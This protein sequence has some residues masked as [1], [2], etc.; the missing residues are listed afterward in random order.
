MPR[1]TKAASASL[2]SWPRSWRLESSPSSTAVQ[3]FRPRSMRLLMPCAGQNESWKKSTGAAVAIEFQ[4]N[5]RRRGLVFGGRS[6]RLLLHTF[7]AQGQFGGASGTPGWPFQQDTVGIIPTPLALKSG[8]F[9]NSKYKKAA[10]QLPLSGL[11]GYSG[12][13]N[14][15]P[16]E[17]SKI[18]YAT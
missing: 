2:Q 5:E 3:E 9:L 17:L 14:I 11:C 1:W 7:W 18:L 8:H 15:Q 13:V 4:S 12:L 16:S 6:R 10:T